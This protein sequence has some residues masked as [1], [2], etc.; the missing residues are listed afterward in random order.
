MTRTPPLTLRPDVPERPQP[1]VVPTPARSVPAAHRPGPTVNDLVRA[2]VRF[3]IEAVTDAVRVSI[4]DHGVLWTWDQLILPVW[5]ALGCGRDDTGEPVLSER[6]FSRALFQ[7]LATTLQ[8]AHRVPAQ[9]LL[10]CAD[11]EERTLPLD[12]L[13][14]ALAEA[15]VSTC[16]LGARVPPQAVGAA[17]DRLQPAVVLIWSQVADTADPRQ[18]TSHLTSG[19]APTVIAAG[20]GWDPQRS[21]RR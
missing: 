3:D 11:E 14:A 9:V 16:V 21:P 10:A 18:I 2:A 13:A 19:L 17:A 5:S 4:A 7:V 6:L 1:S 8:P 12:A 20:P 15:G